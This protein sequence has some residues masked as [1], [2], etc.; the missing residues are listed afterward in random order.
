MSSVH[1]NAT[2][3]LLSALTFLAGIPSAAQAQA[4]CPSANEAVKVTLSNPSFS[5]NVD[6]GIKGWKAIE[7]RVRGNYA[8]ELDTKIFHSAPSSAQIR[9]VSPED[10]GV[11]K[12]ETLIPA[13]WK[14]KLAKLSGYLRT[15]KAMG[16][17]GALVLHVTDGSNILKWNHMSD[18]RVKGT[19]DWKRY[20]IEL[21]I[22]DNGYMLETAVM[23]E[24]DGALWVDDLNLEITP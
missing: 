3:L 22:P 20:T 14:G 1:H 11:L 15:D 4:G 23:L 17:G 6:G 24:D 7:H 2:T 10:Y 13:C 12:Q 18:D 19:Q 5:E 21:R 16:G 9:Q 8:F